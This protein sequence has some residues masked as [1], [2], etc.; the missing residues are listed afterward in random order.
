MKW[1]GRQKKA[2]R[3]SIK[4]WWR[5]LVGI[6][7]AIGCNQCQCCQQYA[8]NNCITCPIQLITKVADCK[9]TPYEE[10]YNHISLSHP[11]SPTHIVHAG[12]LQCKLLIRKEWKFLKRI[13]ILGE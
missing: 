11:T 5:L 9:N 8:K 7:D 6:D 2:L 4:H 3:A 13:L 10:L 1:S 12:C